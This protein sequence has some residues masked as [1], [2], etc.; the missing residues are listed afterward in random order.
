LELAATA[1]VLALED[2]LELT[3]FLARLHQQAV[4]E[5]LLLLL[6]RVQH[7]AALVVVVHLA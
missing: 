2:Q 1:A 7:L 6:A 3:Q 5:V 4:A